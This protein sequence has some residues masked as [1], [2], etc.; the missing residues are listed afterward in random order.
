MPKSSHQ[1]EF[2]GETIMPGFEL[3]ILLCQAPE[4]QD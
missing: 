3:V 4:F 2:F 1:V